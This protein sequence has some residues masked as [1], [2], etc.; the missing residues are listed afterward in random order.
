MYQDIRFV[1]RE[2]SVRF[3]RYSNHS[4]LSQYALN[5]QN[6]QKQNILNKMEFNLNK[7]RKISFW[8]KPQSHTSLPTNENFTITYLYN[9]CY[10]Q[11]T[12]LET[13]L[14]GADPTQ[15]MRQWNRLTEEAVLQSNLQWNKHSSAGQGCNKSCTIQCH[16]YTYPLPCQL[17][18][19]SKYALNC[20]K[21][22]NINLL[23]SKSAN[24][25]S[26]LVKQKPKIN[27]KIT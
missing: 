5:Y 23:K 12:L 14:S 4:L 22:I 2:V 3:S 27:T 1:R 17:S 15:R 6:K 26:F 20:T 19:K 21:L 24:L 16:I 13:A 25:R 11:C 9:S 10:R 18:K 7:L 8:K